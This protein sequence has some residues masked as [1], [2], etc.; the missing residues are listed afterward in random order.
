M[1]KRG[2]ATIII[3]LAIV[4]ISII[5]LFFFIKSK[6]YLGGSKVE[7]LRRELEP[8]TRN[9]EKCLYDLTSQYATLIGQQGGYLEQA[10]GAY[11]LYNDKRVS[12]LCYNIPKSFGCSNR[13]LRLKDMEGQLKSAVASKLD[14]C[15]QIN[16]FKKSGYSLTAGDKELSID[17]GSDSIIASLQYPVK[18]KKENSEAEISAFSKSVPLP[19][20]RLY[21][22]AMYIVNMKSLARI[23]DS[24]YYSI[25]QSELTGKPYII[26]KIQPYP[27]ELFILKIKGIPEENNPFVFQFL[28]EGEAK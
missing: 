1:S 25:F 28:I 11:F 9:I 7:N 19:L 15:I 5:L 12:F 26:Q 3:F 17:I 23:F 16:S 20:G 13:Y 8:I 6:V 27:H 2:Q 14:S 22:A 21:S 18:I 4:I 10:E 24:A